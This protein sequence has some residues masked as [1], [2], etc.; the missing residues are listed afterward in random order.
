MTRRRMATIAAANGVAVTAA[1]IAASAYNPRPSLQS[2][3]D[4]HIQVLNLH[5][6]HRHHWRPEKECG[7]A[8]LATDATLLDEWSMLVGRPV[9]DHLAPT[10]PDASRS[11]P[12]PA[13]RTAVRTAAFGWVELLTRR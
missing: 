5:V 3:F 13:W 9:H 7:C 12:P 4:Y 11:F 1:A 10:T 8:L 6:R 2:A